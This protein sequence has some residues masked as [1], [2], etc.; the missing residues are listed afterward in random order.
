MLSLRE[1]ISQALIAVRAN[2]LRSILTLLIIAVGITALVGIL[3]AIDGFV[4]SLG[5]NLSSLGSNSFNIFPKG[6]ALKGNRKGMAQKNGDLISL[7][8][9]LAFKERF[10]GGKVSVDATASNNATVKYGDE[11]TNP[12]VKVVGVDDNYLNINDYDVSEGREFSDNEQ[13][14]GNNRAIIGNDLVKT[15]FNGK[16]QKALGEDILI[17]NIKYK[18]VGIL[19]SKGASMNGNS[20]RI[21]LIPLLNIK[22]YYAGTGSNHRITVS[23]VNPAEIEIATSQAI[24][25]F[26]AIRKLPLSKED[27]FEIFKS[28]TMVGILEDN[29]KNLRLGATVIGLM[30]LLGASIGLMNIMLVSVTERTREI[31]IRKALGAT[32]RSILMQFLMEAIVI[33]QLGGILGIFAGIFIGFMVTLSLGGTFSIP[34]AWIFG[35]IFVCLVVGLISGLY[36]AMKAAK[37]DPIES[38]RYE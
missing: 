11:K 27:D 32:K 36:P 28:D 29:T 4:H 31:G 13:I 18:V 6:Q 17:G 30:T 24:G 34:W 20:D 5:S 33:C 25:L 35:G 14:T 9:A 26:R 3:A 38:L 7:E 16:P 10:S 15:L 1:I 37:L 19:G 8:E 23:V 2:M 12:T 22:K 21:I